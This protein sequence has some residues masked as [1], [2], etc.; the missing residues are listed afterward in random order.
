MKTS[1]TLRDIYINVFLF[2]ASTFL[3][4]VIEDNA[5]EK[6]DDVDG[7]LTNM[8]QIEANVSNIFATGELQDRFRTKYNIT[9]TGMT[10][11]TPATSDEPKTLAKIARIVVLDQA[12]KCDAQTPCQVQPRLMVADEDGNVAANVGTDTHPW[13]IHAYLN[14]SSNPNASL[15]LQTST[16]V[17]NGYANFTNLGI[18]DVADSFVVAYRFDTPQGVNE[19]MFD[20]GDVVT[21]PISSTLPKLSCMQ[22]G[23]ALEVDANSTFSMTISIVDKVSGLKIPDVNW[24]VSI[25]FKNFKILAYLM[26]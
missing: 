22:T 6:I 14:S 15:I 16:D 24:N 23:E 8:Q 25:V 4:L 9:L 17:M 12:D 21:D 5:S 19:T 7:Q 3:S 1:C 13:V 18:S 10:A 11:Q 2:L 20:P 26:I